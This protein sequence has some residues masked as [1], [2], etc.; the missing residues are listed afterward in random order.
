MNQS[1]PSSHL[2]CYQRFD[3][4]LTIAPMSENI[5]NNEIVNVQDLG[6]LLGEF[7][8]TDIVKPY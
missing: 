5:S 7:N 4:Y 2:M 8:K 3:N 6:F 1:M